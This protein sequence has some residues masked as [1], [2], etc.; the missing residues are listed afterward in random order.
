[1]SL[2]RKIPLETR[3]KLAADPFYKKCCL[4]K[5]GDCSGRIQW[6]HNQIYAGQRQDEPYTI[7]PVC[8][9]HHQKANN[10]IIRELLDVQMFIRATATDLLALMGRDKSG[11]WKRRLIYVAE[12]YDVKDEGI[13]FALKFL[14]EP[15]PD[16]PDIVVDQGVRRPRREGEHREGTPRWMGR[17]LCQGITADPIVVDEVAPMIT[18]HHQ[19]LSSVNDHAARQTNNPPFTINDIGYDPATDTYHLSDI[20]RHVSRGTGNNSTC[21]N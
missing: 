11:Y 1:M 8:E 2:T 12:K 20:V 15:Y 13:R 16:N 19:R 10:K 21:N 5:Y 6:H 9:A 3:N 7:L 18:T 14:D 4:A 17:G